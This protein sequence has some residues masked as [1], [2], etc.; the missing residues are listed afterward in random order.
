[1]PKIKKTIAETICMFDTKVYNTIYD[2]RL[3]SDWLYLQHGDDMTAFQYYDWCEML[4][5]EFKSNFLKRLGGQLIYIELLFDG[6]PVIIAPLHV[7]KT[8]IEFRGFGYKRGVY[9]IG[10]KG[11]SDYLNFIYRTISKEVLE[12]LIEKIFETTGLNSIYLK[13]I[14]EHTQINFLLNNHFESFGIE[15]TDEEGCV[16]LLLPSDSGDFRS[17]LSKNLRSNINKQKNRYVREQF[18]IEYNLLVGINSDDAMIKR[19]LEI[20]N[21]RFQEKNKHNSSVKLS[22]MLNK[23]RKR[24]DE[25]EYAMR[26][27]EHSWLLTGRYNGTIIAY[28]WGLRDSGAIRIMQLGFAKQYTKYMPGIMTVLK[29]I[30]DN[31]EELS[32]KV[33]DFTRGEER[34][35]TELGGKRHL[36]CDYVIEKNENIM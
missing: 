11:Y 20:H 6:K 22:H 5:V 24:F 25:I 28:F 10:M 29:Y 1:M 35:K 16:A 21:E 23:F 12:Y 18:S 2:E 36:I 13:Q 7:Q 15:K 19:I 4:E 27:N 3:K 8:T 14:Q 31:Y 30:Q 17:G 32:G 26:T 9:L 33:I 34:Y